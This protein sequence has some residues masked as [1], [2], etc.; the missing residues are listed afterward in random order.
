MKKIRSYALKTISPVLDFKPLAAELKDDYTVVT[1]EYLRYG[2]S[3][4]TDTPRTI[5]NIT[6]EIHT[7]REIYNKSKQ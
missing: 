1:V 2:L 7:A 3:G 4:L 6:S 5:E